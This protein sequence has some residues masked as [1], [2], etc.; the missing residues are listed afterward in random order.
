MSDDAPGLR[1]AGARFWLSAL[2]GWLLIAVGLRGLFQHSIDTRPASL[3]W[4]VL[5]GALVHDLLVAP[6]VLLVAVVVGRRVPG[7]ARP[8][9]QAAIVVTAVIVLFSYPLVRAYGLATNNPTS[10]PHNYARNLTVVVGV[11]WA[12]AAVAILGR[13]RHRHPQPDSAA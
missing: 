10:L 4:F 6:F 9:V 8:V 5:G 7:W 11:I 3:A 13:L 1:R 12:I 2:A